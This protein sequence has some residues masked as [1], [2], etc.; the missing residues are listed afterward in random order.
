MIIMGGKAAEADM[1]NTNGFVNSISHVLIDEYQDINA[2]QKF[3]ID[4]FVNA[5]S[6]LWVVGDDKQAIYEWR[7][8]SSDFILDYEGFYPGSKIIALKTNYRSLPLIVEK[9]NKLSLHFTDNH[10]STLEADR[11]GAGHFK[12]FKA[13]N[14]PTRLLK[15]LRPSKSGLNLELTIVI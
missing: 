4:Q 5:G 10:Q 9:A 15:S 1:Q 6:N 2:A 7:G 3:L 13:K 8:S 14:D 11:T 12:V